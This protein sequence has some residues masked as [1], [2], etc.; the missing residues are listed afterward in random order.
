M[1]RQLATWITHRW[2]K[3]VVFLVA[4]V[5][6]GALGSLGSKL[7]GQQDNDIAS[8]LPGDAESTEV[9]NKSQQFSNPDDIPA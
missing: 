7:P 2:I 1:Q 4:L 3:W 9:I 8:W 5:I 6:L